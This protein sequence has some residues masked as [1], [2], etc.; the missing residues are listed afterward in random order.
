MQS[1]PGTHGT[2]AELADPEFG[3]DPQWMVWTDPTGAGALPE[4]AAA[5][6]SN[7]PQWIVWAD[8]AGEAQWADAELDH[9]VGPSH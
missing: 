9:L 1:A 7:E 4:R 6:L 5:E 2:L 3:M 8:P